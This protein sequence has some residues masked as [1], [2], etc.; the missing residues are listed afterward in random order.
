ME[1]ET[2]LD[3]FAETD[4]IGKENARRGAVGDFLRDEKLMR[5]ERDTSTDETPDFAGTGLV[6]GADRR[7]PKRPQAWVVA[8]AGEEA[9]LRSLHVHRV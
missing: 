9:L 1:N 5:N 7:L 2:G 4:F 8:H 6:L 3:G